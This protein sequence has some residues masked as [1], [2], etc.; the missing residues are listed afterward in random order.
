MNGTDQ[1]VLERVMRTRRSIR[2]FLP[3][4]PTRDQIERAIAAAA[5]A[6][7]ATNKPSWKVFVIGNQGKRR[8][9][10][11]LVRKRQEELATHVDGSMVAGF[12]SYAGMFSI[13]VEAPVVLA[14][15]IRPLRLMSQMFEGTDGAEARQQARTIE[16]SSAQLGAGA[17]VQNLLLAAHAMGLGATVMTGPLIAEDDL[18][19]LIGFPA[20]WRLAAL[21]PL[22]IPA[23]VPSV[24]AKPTIPSLAR[25]L[26]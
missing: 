7:A 11:D 26:D 20:S 9:M 17:A 23:I 4:P 18:R 16:D 24:P 1:E 5:T 6:P 13:F 8:A 2:E 25:W 10:V 3:E 22:G 12:R 15:I 19:E 21:I 14:L